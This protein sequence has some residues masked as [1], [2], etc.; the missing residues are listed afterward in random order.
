MLASFLTALRVAVK[1]AK[2]VRQVASSRSFLLTCSRS[3]FESSSELFSL[4]ARALF[5]YWRM[6]SF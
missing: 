1:S 6:L 5:W 3:D 4:L 2:A